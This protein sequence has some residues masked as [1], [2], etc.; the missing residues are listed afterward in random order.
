[1]RPSTVIPVFFIVCFLWPSLAF[2][3][4]CV[5]ERIPKR[6]NEYCHGVWKSVDNTNNFNRVIVA[7]ADY[8]QHRR[9]DDATRPCSRCPGGGVLTRDYV[10]AQDACVIPEIPKTTENPEC[11]KN[12]TTVGTVKNNPGV[13]DTCVIPDTECGGV[14]KWSDNTN[15]FNRVVKV[16]PDEFEHRNRNA[17]RPCS[18][19]PSGLTL[20]EDKNGNADMCVWPAVTP[21]CRVSFSLIV[22]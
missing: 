21:S 13:A 22:N 17:H 14:W 3:D 4:I 15:H 16:G 6:L 20:D 18:K 10:G 5:R 9:R 8:F 11:R 1:M 19:C 7:G 12:S 2:A